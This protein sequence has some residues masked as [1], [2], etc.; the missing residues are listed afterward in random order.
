MY[1]EVKDK[2]SPGDLKKVSLHDY[3]QV[4]ASASAWAA[5]SESRW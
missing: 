4:P 2:L 1:D 3:L 5:S